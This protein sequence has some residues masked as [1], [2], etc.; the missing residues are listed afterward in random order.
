[1]LCNRASPV[2]KTVIQV[3][4]TD[5]ID[6]FGRHAEASDDDDVA[7][8]MP[9]PFARLSQFGQLYTSLDSWVTRASLNYI[10]VQLPLFSPLYPLPLCRR[11]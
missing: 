5:V 6:A 10:Q 8:T 4:E 1:M 7:G 3:P 2:Q 9:R 11:C